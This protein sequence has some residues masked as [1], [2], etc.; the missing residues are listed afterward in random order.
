[1][2]R[3][4]KPLKYYLGLEYSFNAIADPD[5]GYVVVFPD[6]PGCMTQ[7]ESLDEIPYM[8]EDVRV[9]WLETVYDSNPNGIPLPSYPVDCG[10]SQ[11]AKATQETK[12]LEYYLGLEYSFSAIADPDGGYVVVFPDLPGCITQGDTLDEVRRMA[13]EARTLWIEAEYDTDPN[14]IP[15]PSYP[16]G[17]AEKSSRKTRE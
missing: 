13:E 9:G 15:L 7:V 6:L 3:E 10:G 14:G 1:M 16:A 12:P 8:A 11:V 5:G 4:T 2:A 17:L